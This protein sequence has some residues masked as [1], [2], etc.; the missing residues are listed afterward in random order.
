M[1]AFIACQHPSQVIITLP[2]VRIEPREQMV[3]GGG[4]VWDDAIRAVGYLSKTPAP[5]TVRVLIPK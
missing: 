2:T 4:I 3:N 1:V 5:M